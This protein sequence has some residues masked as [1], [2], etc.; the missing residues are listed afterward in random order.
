MINT[1]FTIIENKLIA[2]KVY[3]L[4]L[5]GNELFTVKAGQFVNIQL[6]GYFLRRPISV[7]DWTSN[8]LRLIYKVVGR[9]TAELATYSPG[10]KLDLLLPLGKEFKIENKKS[11]NVYKTTDIN[12]MPYNQ[13]KLKEENENNS[14][15]KS[16]LI[17][18]GGVGT[19]PLYGLAKMLQKAGQSPEIILGFNTEN[20]IFLADEFDALGLKVTIC[21]ADG[22]A[23][24]KGF[25]T[26]ALKKIPASTKNNPR[27]FYTCGPLPM[28]HSVY[29]LAKKKQWSG[30]FSLEERMGCGFGACMGC[31]IQTKKGALRI[32]KEGPVIP[33]ETLAW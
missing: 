16:P 22:S 5:L 8:S 13:N 1:K 33:Q 15:S 7:C 21:T 30:Q 3:N 11:C 17:I 9:G 12:N 4:Q 27:I 26:E 19:P 24:I 28:L 23:G 14:L 18:G 10:M 32:C 29:D 6:P 25:V 20:E 2:P 31:S